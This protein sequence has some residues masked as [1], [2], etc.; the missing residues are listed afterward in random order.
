MVQF[1]LA[2]MP[3]PIQR[4]AITIAAISL[5]SCPLWAA[6]KS[7]PTATE[8]TRPELLL[9]GGRRLSWERSFDSELAVKPARGF[10]TKVFDVIAGS[11]E[12]HSLVKPYSV[13][14]DSK[15]R[16]IVTDPGL[17]GVHIFDFAQHKYKFLQRK[18]KE[19]DRMLTPQ[20]VAVDAE[21]NIYVT[22][23]DA[24]VIFV[25]DAN[26]KYRHALGSL[27]GGEGSFKRPTGIAVDSVAQRIYVTDTLRDQVF[28]LSMDGTVVQ[29][30]GKPGQASCLKARLMSL[31]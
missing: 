22:D 21:D 29:T 5:L 24:G 9:E 8:V 28:V 27:R 13:V 15:G 14:T 12:T 25:F 7:K 11:P 19:K 30:I 18:D 16:I 10:F 6:P 3:A 20:C 23:S 31:S 26:G 1:L 2:Q 4:M 17:S